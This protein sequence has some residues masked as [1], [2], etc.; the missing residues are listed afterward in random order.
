MSWS[1]P[2][3]V[4]DLLS[5]YLPDRDLER[6][7]VTTGRPLAF[8]PLI[9]GAGATTFGR[10]VL[11]APGS[12]NP[13]TARGLALIAHEAMHV[14]QFREAGTLRFLLRYLRY[15]VSTRSRGMRHPL[16]APCIR[17]QRRVLSTLREQGWP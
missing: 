5:R 9:L 13:G 3:D 16:E 2:E 8:V 4:V 6:M 10:H 1:L 7:R 15:R 14:R 17:L 12:Y 11:F